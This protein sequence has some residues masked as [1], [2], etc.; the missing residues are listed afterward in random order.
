MTGGPGVFFP[1]W[2]AGFAA[3]EVARLVRER[4]VATSPGVGGRCGMR[5]HC[6]I[7]DVHFGICDL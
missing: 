6:R 2:P 1:D 7:L 5:G 4:G 3:S